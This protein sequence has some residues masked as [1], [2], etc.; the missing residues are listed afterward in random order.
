MRFGKRAP[1]VFDTTTGTPRHTLGARAVDEIAWSPCGRFIGTTN[2][3]ELTLWNATTGA[4]AK[5]LALPGSTGAFA[6]DSGARRVAF[7]TADSSA[8]VITIATGGIAGP[9]T[10]DSPMGAL[11][12]TPD[13][14]ALATGSSDGTMRLWDA[15]TAEP[16]APPFPHRSWVVALAIGPDGRSF[17]SAENGGR[18]NEWRIPPGAPT[19]A[20]MRIIAGKS[21]GGGSSR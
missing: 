2:H 8:R 20:E 9:F 18:V 15:A 5:T 17:F 21:G 10:H 4:P 13:G 1:V 11:A 12:F 6:L 16:L 3:G 14:R 7:S 19:P